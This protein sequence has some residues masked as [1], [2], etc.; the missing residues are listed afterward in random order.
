MRKRKENEEH[1]LQCDSTDTAHRRS[2]YTLDSQLTKSVVPSK[3]EACTEYCL[4]MSYHACMSYRQTDNREEELVC[5]LSRLR[6]VFLAPCR[7]Y[8]LLLFLDH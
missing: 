7:T 4:N 2:I 8:F 3:Y 1:N 5:R 6:L